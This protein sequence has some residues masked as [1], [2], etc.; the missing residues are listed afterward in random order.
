MESLTQL[1][2]WAVTARHSAAQAWDLTTV[3]RQWA[4][5]AW[6]LGKQTGVAVWQQAGTGERIAVMGLAAAALPVGA[7]LLLG[8]QNIARLAITSPV[9]TLGRLLASGKAKAEEAVGMRSAQARQAG[10]GRTDK[11]QAGKEPESVLAYLKALTGLY[12]V[13]REVARIYSLALAE[14]RRREQGGRPQALS[15]HMAFMGPPG[16]GKTTVARIIGGLLHE[17]GFLPQGHLVEVSRKDLVGQYVGETAQKTWA[18]IQQAM[19]GVLFVDEAYA[20][21]RGAENDFGREAVDVLVKAMEDHRDRLCV[22]LAGYEEE[23]D[24]LFRLNPGLESRVARKVRFEHYTPKELCEIACN[25]LSLRGFRPRGWDAESGRWRSEEEYR[26]WWGTFHSVC[27]EACRGNVQRAIGFR[28][29]DLSAFGQGFV[30]GDGRWAR[31]LAERI[32]EAQAERVART[33]EDPWEIT[34]EDVLEGG[35]RVGA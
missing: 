32:I 7:G 23:M 34:P 16:T 19:G 14:Q 35:R 11:A 10:G 8:I 15:W 20:L 24:A 5:Q 31:N 18:A 6:E 12:G 17:L 1:P 30:P 28:K 4:V 26:A 13:K 9:R 25:E 33:G 22:I 21:A 3:A 2:D 29:D 27:Q